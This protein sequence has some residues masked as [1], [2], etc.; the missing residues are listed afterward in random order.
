MLTESFQVALL[1]GY[2]KR[3]ADA[4]EYFMLVGGY[5]DIPGALD[6]P[7]EGMDVDNWKKAVEYFQTD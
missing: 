1:K 5:E 6:N 2:R 4:K 3:K 7:P